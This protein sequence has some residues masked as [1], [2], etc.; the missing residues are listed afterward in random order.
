MG[1]DNPRMSAQTLKVLGAL[2]S[3]TKSELAGSEIA[4]LVQ[5]ASGTLYP[6]LIR[7]EQAEWL[8][9]RWE[10]ED[11]SELGRPRRRLYQMTA[12]GAKKA[13]EQFRQVKAAIGGLAWQ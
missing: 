11:P 9:S 8:E 3:S 2:V 10:E 7:L 6:I 13:A 1:S 12:L 5:V 4:K